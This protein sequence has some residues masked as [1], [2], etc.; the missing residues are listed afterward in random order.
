MSDQKYRV[1]ICSDGQVY[2]PFR[3]DIADL[4]AK[5]MWFQVHLSN[6][7]TAWVQEDCPFDD[8]KPNETAHTLITAISGKSNSYLL[9]IIHFEI[10]VRRAAD[11]FSRIARIIAERLV[12]PNASK[13]RPDR[14]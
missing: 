7:I 11:E 13:R 5:G 1:S 9:G 14:S 4:T 6:A 10:N 2:G 12:I 3:D 8:R